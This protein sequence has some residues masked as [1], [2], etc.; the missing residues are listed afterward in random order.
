MADVW[1]QCVVALFDFVWNVVTSADDPFYPSVILPCCW[2]MGG[3]LNELV[4]FF[5]E[6]SQHALEEDFFS[7]KRITC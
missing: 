3:S 7:R 1:K 5:A 2:G 6:I 4:T